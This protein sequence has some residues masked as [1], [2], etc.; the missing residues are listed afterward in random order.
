MKT[1]SQYTVLAACALFFA[2]DHALADVTLATQ[3][4]TTFTIIEPEKAPASVKAAA[5]EL[6]RSLSQSTGAAINIRKDSET[7]SGPFISLG[8]TKQAKDAG[9]TTSDIADEGFRIVTRNGSLYIQGPDTAALITSSRDSL[10]YDTYKLQPDIPGPQLT[11]D[12]G[13][14]N[15]TANGVYTFL[16]DYLGVRW[17]FPGDLGR[18][19]PSHPNLVIPDLNRTDTPNFIWR[20]FPHLQNTRAVAQWRDQ[21]KLGFSFR[22]NYNHNWVETVPPAM[23]KQ[24]PDWF[25][26]IGGKRPEP[27][28]SGPKRN[29]YKLETT[30]PELV[31]YF[32][33]QAV[34]A[35]KADP[36]SNTFSL[37]SSDSRGWSESPE[38]KALYDPKPE[39]SEF[40]SMTP[41]MLKWY[42]DVAKAVAAKDPQA[43]MAGYLYSDARFLPVNSPASFPKNFYP[44]MVL[45]DG[46]YRLYRE[47]ARKESTHLM[48]SWGKVAPSPW[49]Y[50]SFGN[51][52]RRN[53]G[54]FTPPAPGN[55]NYT[56][57][58]LRNNGIKGARLYGT[59]SW[60]QHAIGNYIQAKL[61]W[62]P[63]LDANELQ[64]E[65]LVRAYGPQAGPVM[66]QFHQKLDGWFA[67]YWQR[68][69][70]AN[71]NTREPFFKNL[72]GVHYPEMEA[73]FLQAKAQPMTPI[74]QQRL[75]LIEQNMVVLQWRLRNA[76]YLPKG[77]TSKLQRDDA[78][79]V[80]LLQASHKDFDYFPDIT[81]NGPALKPVK[82]RLSNAPSTASGTVAVPN[83]NY[84]LLH[85]SQ[86]GPVKLVPQNVRPGSSFLNY[87]LRSASNPGPN[88]LSGFLYN[89]APINFEAKAGETYYFHVAPTGVDVLPTATWELRIAG[90]KP[91]QATFEKDTLTLSGE[92]APLHVFAPHGLPLVAQGDDAGVLLRTKTDKDER[93][94]AIK[95]LD[96]QAEQLMELSTL[97]RFATDPEDKGLQ[98]NYTSV[99]FNDNAWKT[100][101][102]TDWWQHQGFN[103]YNG[104]A[105]YRKSFIAPPTP[106]D[107]MLILFVG[108]V[109]GNADLYI[110]G[111]KIGEHR[112]G[113][114]GAGWNVPFG[115]NVTNNVVTGSNTIAIKVT[116]TNNLGGI[117]KGVS[118]L[119]MEDTGTF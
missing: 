76:Q 113:K 39:G 44:V 92:E 79:V 63:S 94:D 13:F 84:V 34:K 91:A 102:T 73:L 68:Y 38:S 56:F 89:D 1:V 27:P 70:S 16:E 82:V 108:A 81:R 50:Y 104:T 41:L 35:L 11:K 85:A 60:S 40:P 22:L 47:A 75:E 114:D 80:A 3:G 32:A 69:E 74:Q 67:Q 21:Q 52:L 61:L 109:D 72:F 33:E 88:L 97:W 116:K 5:L 24:H 107:Q 86:D 2:A 112:L 42:H 48:E 6:K 59:S 53:S 9:L 100:V 49:F 51:W 20:D 4:K 26:M 17:L 12:G 7:V 18:D 93:S 95:K 36:N 90:A 87:T 57:S 28:T 115:F 118:L 30:N 98:N 46:G 77:F 54:F 71:H 62:N 65:W 117:H 43:K 55:L 103:N 111:K 15:G 78:A 58:L 110:N 105:W 119:T 10:P 8:A 19:V 37:S 106:V 29:H 45:G 83:A 14:S 23:Y 96:P 101:T 31:E 25:A 66:E 64:R 99:G